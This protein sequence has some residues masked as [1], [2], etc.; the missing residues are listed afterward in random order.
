MEHTILKMCEVLGVSTSGYYAYVKRLD[1]EET[2]NEAFNRYLDER[3]LHHFYDNF[4]TYGS[5]RIWRKL[6]QVDHLEVSEKKVANRMRA[7][8]L[9][10]TQPKKF[11]NTTDSAHARPTFSN[12]L[13][14]AFNPDAPNQVWATDITYIHTGEGFL[15]LNPVMDLYSRRIISYRMDDHMGYELSLNALEEAI[16][17]RQ[18]KAG[19][20]H[21][22][23]RGSQYCSNA[24]LSALE[25]AGSDISMS[26]K[27]NPYNNA[28][29][30]SFFATLKKEYLY[31]HVF[32]TKTEAILA[33]QFYIKFYN[34][35]RMH[36]SIGY[37]SPMEKE[38][39]YKKDQQDRIDK[40]QKPSA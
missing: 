17:L 30:E 4:G 32:A 26:R 29:A 16:V 8:N 12:K 33:I 21:H 18:P 23:D 24:Y 11:V 38:M 40:E 2:E 25:E 20:V 31:R 34:E 22:S 37:L 27:A 7:L 28:C 35:K 36:S 3:I 5:P 13:N 9:Y 19:W 1:R 15:Y 39:V 6:R 14:Q 10:A